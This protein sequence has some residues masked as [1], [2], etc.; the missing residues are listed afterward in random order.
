MSAAFQIDP[1]SN[2]S[3]D[4]F[5]KFAKFSAVY[6]GLSLGST[7]ISTGLIVYR[8]VA[9]ARDTGF[10]LESSY[11]KVLEIIVESAFLYSIMLIIYV[12]F[13]VRDDFSDAYPQAV[14]TSMIV[15]RHA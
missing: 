8:I 12:P 11:R 2:L 14:L 15:S 4:D 10:H 1:N 9:V 6:F 7:T 5:N 13:L 3:T